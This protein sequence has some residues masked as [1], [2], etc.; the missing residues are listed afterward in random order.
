[1]TTRTPW[2]TSRSDLLSLLVVGAAVIVWQAIGL[3]AS[4][5]QILPT[6]TPRSR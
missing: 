4:V 1:M 5:A 6:R 2:F 3:V